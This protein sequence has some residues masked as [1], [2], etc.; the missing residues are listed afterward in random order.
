VAHVS[1]E[2]T[3]ERLGRRS[4]SPE[5]AARLKALIDEQYRLMDFI[6]EHRPE[7]LEQ[8]PDRWIAIEGQNVIVDA[9]S[10][11][12]LIDRLRGKGC[13]LSRVLTWFMATEPRPIWHWH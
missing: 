2:A 13:D 3:S 4:L 12:E 10:S 1:R 8:F 5:E 6:E 7:L 11:K 9:A